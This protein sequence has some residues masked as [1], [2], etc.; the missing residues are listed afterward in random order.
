MEAS[1]LIAGFAAALAGEGFTS[2]PNLLIRS[3]ASLGISDRQL[4][5]LLHLLYLA[6]SEEEHCP[7]TARLQQLMT[8]SAAEIESD[9]AQLMERKIIRVEKRVSPRTTGPEPYYSLEGLFDQLSEV[10]AI[11]K[12]N[13]IESGKRLR[14]WRGSSPDQ[15]P[16]LYQT[17]EKEF[18]RPLSPME[19]E[20]ISDWARSFSAELVL[21]ALRIAV[22]S[23]TFNLRYIERILQD[24]NRKNVRTLEEVRRMEEAYRE[25]R[26]SPRARRGGQSQRKSGSKEDKTEWNYGW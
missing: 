22:L 26:T 16:R 25:Q 3:Y 2:I 9:L 1:N 23:G 10:W 21:E 19:G 14:S 18:G 11:E 13:E 5:L 4:V 6:Q 17:F 15:L 20:L 8:A 7:P 24:W 12:A